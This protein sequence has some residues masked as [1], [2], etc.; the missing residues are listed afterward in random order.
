[1]E[2]APASVE[3]K[4]PRGKCNALGIGHSRIYAVTETA[5]HEPS[6]EAHQR[7]AHAKGAEETEDPEGKPVAKRFTARPRRGKDVVSHQAPLHWP[8]S[9]IAEPVHFTS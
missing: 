7:F 9:C 5:Q 6:N 8:A 3:S 4:H 2:T 1:M